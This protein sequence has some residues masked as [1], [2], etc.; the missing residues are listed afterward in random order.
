MSPLAFGLLIEHLGARALYVSAALSLIACITLCL[1]RMP[2]REAAP[3][4]M[5]KA[6]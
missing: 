4:V 6:P 1:L 3:V 5:E 2:R